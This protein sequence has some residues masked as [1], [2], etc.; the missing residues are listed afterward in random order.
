MQHEIGI[1]SDLWGEEFKRAIWDLSPVGKAIVCTNGLFHKVNPRFAEII[2]YSEPEIV[3]RSFDGI[4]HPDDTKAD[5]AAVRMLQSGELEVYNMRKRYL[6]KIGRP[7]WCHLHVV[8]IHHTADSRLVTH[9]LSTIIPIDLESFDVSNVPLADISDRSIANFI[10]SNWLKI[11][12]AIGLG[13]GAIS[14]Y[15]SDKTRT[16]EQVIQTQKRLD[17]FDKRHEQTQKKIE[18]LLKEISRK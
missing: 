10:K 8:P 4:T 16:N 17:E 5:W 1:P 13:A 2:G 11:A 6:P 7:I 9:F 15:S 12:T 14:Q 18:E 3:G